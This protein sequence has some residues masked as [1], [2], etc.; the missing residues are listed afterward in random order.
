MTLWC[1][2]RRFASNKGHRAAAMGTC[3]DSSPDSASWFE[4]RQSHQGITSPPWRTMAHVGGGNPF[5]WFTAKG[6]SG[7]R[8]APT[9][10]V[11]GWVSWRLGVSPLK[12]ARF[13]TG[14][15]GSCDE[16]MYRRALGAAQ[17]AGGAGPL[18]GVRV[19]RGRP[20]RRSRSPGDGQ[21]SST[22]GA[23]SVERGSDEPLVS[24]QG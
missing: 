2:T 22:L 9:G 10:P 1:Y 19:A 11:E 20:R 7:G 3:G 16:A 18:C 6:C 17:N 13:K 15:P 24:S 21:P 4:T 8:E 5:E 23:E 14:H 12:D